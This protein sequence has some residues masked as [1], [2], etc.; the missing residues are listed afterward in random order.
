MEKEQLIQLLERISD[1]T[2]SD[3]DMRWYNNWCNELQDEGLIIENL[4]QIKASMLA[5]VEKRIH[6]HA[7]PVVKKLWLRIAVAACVVLA[8]LAGGYVFL[9]DSKQVQELVIAKEDRAPGGNKAVLTLGNGQTIVLDSISNGK[10]AG[11]TGSSISKPENGLLVYSAETTISKTVQYNILRTPRG[12]Q[13]KV[14]LPDGTTVW[15]NAAS[16]IRYPTAFNGSQRTVSITGEAYFEVIHDAAKPFRVIVMGQTIED[17]GTKFNINAY[18]DEP[19]VKTTLLHGSVSVT[20]G[21]Q[22]VV[23]KP[24]QQAV[25]SNN[26]NDVNVQRVDTANA[27]AW[28]NGF[29]SLEHMTVKEFMNRL[30]RWYN[31][32]VDYNGAIPNKKFGGMINRNASLSDVLSV[33][34]ASGIHTRLERKKIIVLPD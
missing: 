10:L 11:Q 5:E 24:G 12:G 27:V 29:M 26:S 22:Q 17:L 2:A 9:H 28:I 14:I 30:S 4:E 19:F 16:S 18:G 33:L 31:V 6:S 20:K 32:D 34:D 21:A 1:G 13:Y 8:L 25:V 7:E 23:L 3:E 15:L